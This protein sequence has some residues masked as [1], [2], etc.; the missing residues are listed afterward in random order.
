MILLLYLYD[1][2]L[3]GDEELIKDAKKI[4][5]AKFEMKDLGMTH[6]LLVMEV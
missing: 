4:L 1:L 3:T 2:Y 5:D 6:Y